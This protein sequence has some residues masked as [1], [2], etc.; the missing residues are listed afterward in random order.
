MNPVLRR[1]VFLLFAAAIAGTSLLTWQRHH[2]PHFSNLPDEDGVYRE[3]MA[4][5][6]TDHDGRISRQEWEANGGRKSVFD[7]YDFN[8]DGFLDLAEFKAMF[9]E[10]DPKPG[11]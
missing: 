9:V 6:D 2:E 5:I 7:A 8:H 11:P 3:L 4:R 10:V 1:V